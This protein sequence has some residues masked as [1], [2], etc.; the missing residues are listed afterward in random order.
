[1]D[2]SLQELENE[3]KRLTPRQPSA[4]LRERIGRELAAEAA[5]P[6]RP[7]VSSATTF[8][9][10][11]WAGWRLAAV[12]AA[13]AVVATIA[14]RPGKS[15][16]PAEATPQLVQRETQVEATSPASTGRYRPVRAANV[17][18]DLQDEGPVELEDQTPARRLRYRYVDTYTWQNPATN[19]SLKWS[20]PREEVRVVPVRLN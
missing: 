5:V 17:L 12:A 6:V 3:L 8:T 11:K 13:L 9:S 1:M 10:W 4:A 19:A 2:E 18:Y 20:V 16:A 7:R 14:L 15:V